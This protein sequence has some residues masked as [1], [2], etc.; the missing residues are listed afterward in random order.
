MTHSNRDGSSKLVPRCDLPL[1]AEGVV[2]LIITDLAVFS[3]EKGK[4]TLKELMPGA[5]LDEVQQG[6][7]AA[8]R[9]ALIT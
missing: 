4:L 5:T 6:T 8:F 3:F 7:N 1:T 2:D 9:D